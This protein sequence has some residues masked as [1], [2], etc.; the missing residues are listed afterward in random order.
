MRK[1]RTSREIHRAARA[2]AD[3]TGGVMISHPGHPQAEIDAQADRCLS[4]WP[5]GSSGGI[6]AVVELAKAFAS[7]LSGEQARGLRPHRRP[8]R[9][10]RVLDAQRHRAGKPAPARGVARQGH[11]LRRDHPL[12]LAETTTARL[13]SRRKRKEITL[14]RVFVTGAS[15]WIGSA[16]VEELLSAG[17]HVVG[18]A[19]SEDS[20]ASI[21]GKGAALLRGNL[22]DPDSLPRGGAEADA[23]VHLANKHD[24]ANPAE[25]DRAERAAVETLADGLVGTDRPFVVAS[26]VA[27]LAVGRPSTEADP[28]R[29]LGPDSPRGGAENLA[30]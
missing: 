30:L 10:D 24:W 4:P 9:V 7:T 27:G 22:D 28:S 16:T 29:A 23:V 6:V 25:S 3:H 12:T 8:V 13:A 14:M 17:H 15:G 26:G 20:A 11:R 21:K 2:A 18:L 19:Q 1:H 5:I